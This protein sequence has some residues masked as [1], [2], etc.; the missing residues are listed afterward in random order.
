MFEALGQRFSSIFSGLRGKVSESDLKTFTSQI[1][2]A[3]LESDVSLSV[4]DSFSNR[5]YEKAVER[6]EEINKSINPAQ[7][8]F[9]IVNLE[10]TQILGGESR[11]VRYAKTSPTVIL[12]IEFPLKSRIS[13]TVGM[14]SAEQLS[15]PFTIGISDVILMPVPLKTVSQLNEETKFKMTTVAVSDVTC[16]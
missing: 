6:S 2:N 16:R 11:R 12:L 8:I 10:L 7:K 13:V 4:A 1:K 9:E 15:G 14:Q 3:L 5:I